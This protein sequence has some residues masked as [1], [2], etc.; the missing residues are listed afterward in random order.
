MDKRI[1]AQLYT[2]REFAKTEEE[3]DAT[4]S[5]LAKVGYKSVQ[6]SGV[7]LSI[8]PEKIHEI[9]EKYSLAVACT[10]KGFDDYR[11]KMD[12]MIRFHKIIECDIAGLGGLPMDFRS[13]S[14]EVVD[15]AID[16][17]NS[18]AEQLAKEGITFAYHNHA[19]EFALLENGQSLFDRLIERGKFAF[20]LDAY[21]VAAAGVDVPALV[22][23][24]GERVAVLHLK[25][26]KAKLDN[27]STFAPVGEGNIDFAKILE[28]S[29]NV[30]WAMVE[31]DTCDGEDPVLCLER[32][33]K[34]LTSHFDFI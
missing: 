5:R 15:K 1:G 12:E 27:T 23:K 20:I 29:A 11:D 26:M 8:T 32:S 31:Q 17:L 18:F 2:V 22:E 6:V 24:L 13:E 30:R 9:C 10:H 14:V 16:M 19:F 3:L 34:Y 25:D 4:L 7:G 28:K 33:Y 21:W